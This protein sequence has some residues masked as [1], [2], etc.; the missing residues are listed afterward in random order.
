MNADRTAVAFIAL[1]HAG[2]IV[3]KAHAD[4]GPPGPLH[5]WERATPVALI[6]CE[7]HKDAPRAFCW[8]RGQAWPH[9]WCTTDL[10]H[11]PAP[12]MPVRKYYSVRR[13]HFPLDAP[14]QC[15]GVYLPTLTSRGS[16]HVVIRPTTAESVCRTAARPRRR[17]TR[18]LAYR[19]RKPRKPP[20]PVVRPARQPRSVSMSSGRSPARSASRRYVRSA[21]A[22]G[23][24]TPELDMLRLA[25]EANA[26]RRICT[27]CHSMRSR[28]A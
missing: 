15:C 19:Q 9:S 22:R 12:S 7:I 26:C 8:H 20:R 23:P 11:S 27:T 21:R 4:R 25:E 2:T 14:E 3:G 16:A 24:M 6:G 10:P 17:R 18:R 1:D 5:G 13:R 28:G